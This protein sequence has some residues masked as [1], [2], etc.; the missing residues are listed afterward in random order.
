MSVTQ[1]CCWVA[2]SYPSYCNP[3]DYNPPRLLCPWDFPGKNTGVGCHFLL[4]GT[5]PTQGLKN[6]ADSL[7]LGHRELIHDITTQKYHPSHTGKHPFLHFSLQIHVRFF[8]F[9]QKRESYYTCWFFFSPFSEPY[10][11]FPPLRHPL[12]CFI[13][14]LNLHTSL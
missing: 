14:I 8:F 7:Q 13:H 1:G 5:F 9:W 10:S 3:M 12:T 2:K 11:Q 4:Q 6:L